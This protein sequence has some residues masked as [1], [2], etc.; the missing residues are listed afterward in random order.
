LQLLRAL[1]VAVARS[2]RGAKTEPGTVFGTVSADSKPSRKTMSHTVRLNDVLW[3]PAAVFAFTVTT[4]VTPTRHG[5]VVGRHGQGAGASGRDIV[6]IELAGDAGGK[7]ARRQ[8][9]AQLR[10]RQ[11]GGRDRDVG[12]SRGRRCHRKI[13]SKS[14]S[15]LPSMFSRAIL[16]RVSPPIAVK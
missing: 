8:G 14:E 10:S 3:S 15:A 9:D 7:S 4:V 12:A 1:A 5:G 11:D 16:F 6:R 2:W 13:A